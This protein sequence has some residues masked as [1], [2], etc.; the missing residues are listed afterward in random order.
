MAIYLGLIPAMEE[1]NVHNIIVITDSIATAK[2]VFKLKT[3]PLQNMF[4]PVTSAI[5][6]FFRKNGRNKI[7][8]WFL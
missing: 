8:F 1:K 5:D 7:Q 3:D 4:I 2:K 6:S